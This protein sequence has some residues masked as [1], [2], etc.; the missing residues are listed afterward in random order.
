MR[1]SYLDYAMSVIVGARAARRARRAE[2]GAPPR[3]LLDVDERQPPRPAVREVREH[4]RLRDGQPSP[5]RRQRDLRH[6]RPAGAALLAPLSA[7]RRPG[8]LRLDRRRPA[9]RDALHRGPPRAG[10][11]RRCCGELDSDT[12]DFGPNYDE[13]KR[14]PLVLPARFPNLL[15]NGSAGHRRRHGD[16]HPAAPPGRDDRRRRRADRQARPPTSRT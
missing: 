8:Q 4:R 2:A 9:G 1:S 5:A 3:P 10:S 14:E 16:E 7:R 12:V 6:A 15:V 13:S 11:P